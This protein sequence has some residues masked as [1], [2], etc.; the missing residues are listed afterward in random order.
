MIEKNEIE[1]V[2]FIEDNKVK[3]AN[4]IVSKISYKDIE[5]PVLKTERESFCQDF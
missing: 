2:W 4:K 3:K 5:I 1:K